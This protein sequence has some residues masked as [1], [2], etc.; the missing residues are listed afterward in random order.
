M[1]DGAEVAAP[2]PLYV[3]AEFPKE[4]QAMRIDD[5]RVVPF[6]RTQSAQQISRTVHIDIEID[7]IRQCRED[8]RRGETEIWRHLSLEADLRRDATGCLRL[9]GLPDHDEGVI[10]PPADDSLPIT[11]FEE[12]GLCVALPSAAIRDAEAALQPATV[13]AIPLR[14]AG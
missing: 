6:R 10:V 1:R 3:R 9:Y 2:D 14:R 5:H 4:E 8:W 13:V 11:R 7:L 12:P